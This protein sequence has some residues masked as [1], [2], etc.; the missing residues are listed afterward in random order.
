MD[1]PI[2]NSFSL[3]VHPR[4]PKEKWRRRRTV[5]AD[6]CTD[7]LIERIDFGHI[8]GTLYQKQCRRNYSSI[9]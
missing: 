6:I 2:G 7:I 1:C 5:Y 8:F 4:Q 9:L 3:G